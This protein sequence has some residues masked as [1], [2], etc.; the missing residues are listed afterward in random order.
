MNIDEKREYVLTNYNA[1]KSKGRVIESDHNVCEL[2]MN[3]LFCPL[4]QD[5][6]EIFEFKNQESQ[7]L[8]KDLT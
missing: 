2:E 7:K 3:L 8:F 5:R 6:I 1:V 4:K